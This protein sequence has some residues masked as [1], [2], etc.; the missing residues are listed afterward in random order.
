MHDWACELSK[1][2]PTQTSLKK[3]LYATMYLLICTVTF[4]TDFSYS[5]NDPFT[6]CKNKLGSSHS[7]PMLCGSH[8][9]TVLVATV[10]FFSRI[11][12]LVWNVRML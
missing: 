11:G 1:M 6:I 10:L 7:P 2:S 9:I 12:G 8:N 3:I 5:F 4:D